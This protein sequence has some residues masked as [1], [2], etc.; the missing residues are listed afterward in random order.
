[1]HS[2]I[3]TLFPKNNAV[4]QCDNVPID[5]AGTLQSWF[6][7]QKS[8]LR[9]LPWSAQTPDLNIIEPLWSDIE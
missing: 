1:V 7:E 4:F 6:E 8:E 3:Q 9:H 2:I 5:T